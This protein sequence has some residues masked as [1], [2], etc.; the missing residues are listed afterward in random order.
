MRPMKDH[1]HSD[2]EA[3][4]RQLTACLQRLAAGDLSAREELMAVA[5]ERMR[6][7]AH[8]MLQR[9]PTVRRWDQTDDI[10]QNAAMRLY[11]AL[12]DVSP[13]SVRHFT[14]L[15][16]IQIR[17]ELLDLA[18]KYAGPESHAANHQTN[19]PCFNGDGRAVVD[20]VSAP[21]EPTGDMEK[22]SQ[23][24][25]AAASL[26]EDERELFHMVWYL[27]LKQDD[28]AHLLECSVRTIKRRWETA[29][30]LI[31]KAMNGASP[32]SS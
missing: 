32:L 4:E 10:V 30:Q 11:R 18:K 27:G 25:A 28:A 24:H 17:R 3:S 1:S 2:A 29:K 9:F 8:R 12:G 6:Y 5:C 7:I 21:T 19:Y 14:G 20:N 13:Q 31:G 26:P 15:V 22:W 16:A 23:L